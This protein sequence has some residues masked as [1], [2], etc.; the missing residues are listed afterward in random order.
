MYALAKR[1]YPINRSLTGEGVRESL[2]VLREFLP[3]LTLY[4]VPSGTPCFD[5]TIPDEWNIDSGYIKGP[6]GEKIVDFAEHNLHVM[7]YSEPVEAV[8]SLEELN[9]HLYSFERLADAIPYVTSYYERKWGFCLAHSQ[10]QSLKE[11]LYEV[12]IASR[13]EPGSMTYA[14]LIIPGTS[15]EEIL[16]STYICHPSMANNELSG[17]VVATFLAQY[18]QKQT[19]RYTYRFLF[20]PETIGSIYYLSRHHETLK[21]RVIAGFVHITAHPATN[22]AEHPAT[23]R[24]I[25]SV[26]G[27]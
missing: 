19:R 27:F 13:L 11:G 16:I 9:Q 1:L 26:F 6:D 14:E 3:A 4:E 20:V 12:K 23:W 17:P 15:A 25:F 10:R 24:E 7:G 21:Q 18:L 5:W 22:R 8:M 2:G